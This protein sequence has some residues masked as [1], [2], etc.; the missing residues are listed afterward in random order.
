[1]KY[2]L[3]G[4][5]GVN[6][7]ELCFGTMFFGSQ[8]NEETSIEL[9]K[10]ACDQ[11]VNF[12]DTAN[13]YVQ[14]KSEEIVGKAIK[15]IREDIVL[16]TK[17]RHRMGTGANDEGLSRK[18]IMKAVEDSLRRL[19]TDYIDIY[20]VHRPSSARDF[21]TG[22]LGPPVPLKET[23]SALTD[24]VRSGKV[25]YIGCSNFPAWHLCEALWTSDKYGLE[26]FVVVQPP[27]NLLQREIEREIIPLCVSQSLGI[28]SYSPLSGGILTGKYKPGSP[29]PAGSRGE[30]SPMFLKRPGLNWEDAETQK[31]LQGLE[32]LSKELGIT[33]AQLALAWLKAQPAVTAPIMAASN[34]KQLEE[35]LAVTTINLKNED[36]ERIDKIVPA[37]G[38]YST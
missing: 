21:R 36:L 12:I 24:L 11:G 28:V 20:Y 27:Y 33:M 35:N 34:M 14:G 32:E 31:I 22:A 3:L 37:L 6:V 4:K 5:S 25:R 15:G 29:P 18:H 9:I 13:V 2:K 23:L 10:K 1:M 30:I 7:S 38:P 17:V 8:V 19:D 16:A 26:S